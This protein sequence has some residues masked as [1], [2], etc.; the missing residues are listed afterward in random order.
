MHKYEGAMILSKRLVHA[1]TMRFD[2]K[3][4]YAIDMLLSIHSIF[5]FANNCYWS[6]TL[7]PKMTLEKLQIIATTHVVGKYKTK[8]LIWWTS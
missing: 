8:W 3:H 1:Q 2:F 5:W 4:I 7:K 6:S